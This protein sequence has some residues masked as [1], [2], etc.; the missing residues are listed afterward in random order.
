MPGAAL[1][2][3]ATALPPFEL[4]QEEVSA[5]A[6]AI[7]GERFP[8]FRR[9]KAVF[10]ST[11][12]GRR[13]SVRPFDWFA[14]PHG[15]P[16]RTEAFLEGAEALFVQA[17]TQALTAAGLDGAEVDGVVT[18]SSTGIATPSLEA[19]ALTRMGF[20]PDILRVPV[21]GLGCA[22]GVSGLAIAA[23][24]AQARPGTVVLL[25]AVELCT[26]SFRLDQLTS[27]NVVATALFGD[28]AA[29]AVLR[30]GGSAGLGTIEADAGHT[31]PDTLDVMGWSVDPEGLGV[32]FAQ[33]IPPFAEAHLGPA[34]E[35]ML[36]RMGVERGAVDRFV[37]HPGGT[38]VIA[39]L[40]RALDL[41]S[42]ELDA[43]RAVLADCG[44]M[45]SP[46]ALFVLQRVLAQ[47][48]PPAF[49][50]LTALGPGFSAA[51]ATFRRAAA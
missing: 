34:V 32:I 46:T 4:A 5:R 40:E 26:L 13:W 7:F 45:S 48:S 28:G 6:E 9:L 21:F 41:P 38:K 15:W 47:A 29:A 27:A 51:C 39:A 3:L 43:E 44:N 25:V 36:A 42:G 30:A 8:E 23:R 19:R 12:I 20:R 1:L 11:G 17:A 24:L 18:V 10:R 16:D 31:W 2:S 35:G 22:G 50:V 33:S 49:S 14:E 37:C